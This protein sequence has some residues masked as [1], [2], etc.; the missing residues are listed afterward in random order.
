MSINLIIILLTSLVSYYAFNNASLLRKLILYPYNDLREN[1]WHTLFTSGFVHAD[2]NHLFFNMFTLY[3]LGSTAEFLFLD[4]FQ[5]MGL[6]LYP[7]YY[8][9]AIGVSSI[10]AFIKNKD[11][12]GYRALGA[13]GGVSAIIFI[14]ILSGPW[15][16]L[17][18]FGLIPIP[19]CIL[20]VI[21]L[22]YESYM[23]KKG[24]DNIGHDA[25]LTGAVYGIISFCVLFPGMVKPFIEQ[26]LNPSF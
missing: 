13:S 12:P 10:P 8:L 6:L 9:S 26:L 25:H 19:A 21:Y 22:V 11:N 18:I 24:T 2:W 4:Q 15:K 20:G 7:I 5:S 17:Y 16:M 23:S 3:F 1:K 14:F